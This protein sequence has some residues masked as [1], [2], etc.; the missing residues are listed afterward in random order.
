MFG[1][2]LAYSKAMSITCGQDYV[3][4]SE[5]EQLKSLARELLVMLEKFPADY[6][7]A[8]RVIEASH[9]RRVLIAKA[10]ELL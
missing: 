4:R 5:L 2:S 3:H 9:Q 6:Y 10:K 8:D 7:A 1:Q